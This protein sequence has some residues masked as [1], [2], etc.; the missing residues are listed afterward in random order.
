[1]TGLGLSNAT[2]RAPLGERTGPHPLQGRFVLLSLGIATAAGIVFQSLLPSFAA[3]TLFLLLALLWRRDI[4]PALTFCL[5]YQWLFAVTGYFY[6]WFY[7]VYP[8]LPVIGDLDTVVVYSL[9]GLIV[10]ACGV[11]T[12]RSLAPT[13]AEDRGR[14]R[15]RY[16][17]R[18]LF[19]LV[20]GLFSIN[21]LTEVLPM[22]LSYVGA[23]I[24]QNLLSFREVMLCVLFL[25]VARQRTGYRYALLG[26][27]YVFVPLLISTMSDFKDLLFVVFIVLLSEWRPWLRS[28]SDRR[29]NHVI[30]VGA[31]ALGLT[32]L[33]LG[34]VWQARIKPQWR[35]ETASGVVQGSPVERMA[36]FFSTAASSASSLDIDDATALLAARVS[37]GIGYF[38]LVVDRVPRIIPY[39]DGALTWRAIEHVL[40]PRIL[41]PDKP[42][43]GSDSWLVSSYAG[44]HVAGAEQNTSVGLGYIAEMYID[45]GVPGMFL[46]LFLYGVFLGSVEA[47]LRWASPS[48]Q[49]FGGAVIVMYVQHLSNY[50]GEI[51]KQFGGL[52]QTALVFGVLLRLIGP[53]LDRHLETGARRSAAVGEGLSRA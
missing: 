13:H 17:S 11:R 48:W 5:A 30:V 18:R 37:S 36:Q 42:G 26:L 4:P 6:L 14:A 49:L 27:L 45:F 38:S 24:I 32:L 16:D 29:R 34:L 12:V 51:A 2:P 41:F 8:G 21:W 31:A 35:A 9:V 46:A 25:E 44:L 23:Q 50:D 40:E 15:P 10:L 52:L 20:I 39:E 28:A 1:M 33:V 7:G 3:G 43:L 19:W 53:W 47:G 22:E